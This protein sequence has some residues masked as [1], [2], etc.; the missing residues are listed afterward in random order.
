MS[1]PWEGRMSTALA[2][3]ETLRGAGAPV[4]EAPTRGTPSLALRRSVQ[5]VS[6]SG[7]Q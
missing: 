2:C 6:T 3:R 1:R 4:V 7:S 5:K